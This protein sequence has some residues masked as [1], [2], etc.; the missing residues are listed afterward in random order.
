MKPLLIA[1]A[2]LVAI[3][4][5][6]AC[7]RRSPESPGNPL[8]PQKPPAPKVSEGGTRLAHAAGP[9]HPAAFLHSASGLWTLSLPAA[10]PA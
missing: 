1:G 9:D 2:C 4:M 6:G 7:D 8:P 3:L 10:R 5:S